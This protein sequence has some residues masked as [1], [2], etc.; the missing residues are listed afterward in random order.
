MKKLYG[1]GV[2]AGIVLG[3]ARKYAPQDTVIMRTECTDSENEIRVF[4]NALAQACAR[5][6]ALYAKIKVHS[7]EKEAEIFDA[8]L[9]V[10]TDDISVKNPI[11]ELIRSGYSAEQAVS[12]HFSALEDAMT[13]LEDD[14]LQARGS[15]FAA[16]K[17]M[18]LEELLGTG[19]FDLSSL[20]QDVIIVA[21][22]LTP[23]DTV[24][25]DLAHVKG[26]LCET[27]APTSHTAILA[28][29]LG[30]PAVVGCAGA[31]DSVQAG[32]SMLLDGEA[33][34]AIFSPDAHQ[35][36]LGKEKAAKLEQD[37][38]ALKQY[39]TAASRTI[40]GHTVSIHANI[41]SVSEC[42][43]AMKL[44]GEG[45]GLFRTEFLYME[46]PDLPDEERQ[47][48]IY[49][50]TLSAACGKPVTIRTLDAGGDKFISSLN[51]P[52][53]ENP[54]LGYRAIR[55]CLDQPSIFK[56]QL[57]ALYRA[58]TFGPLKIMFPMIGSLEELRAAKAI[59][60]AAQDELDCEGHPYSKD[61]KLGIMV[62]L[63]AV[64]EMAKEF[65]EEVDFFSIGTNDLVQYTLAVDRGNE[66]IKSLYT[67]YHPAVIRM[68][69]KSIDAA[70][71]SGIS[72]SMCGEA[73]GDLMFAPILLGFGLD[74][75]SV[76]A[77]SI[78]KLRQLICQS[79]LAC[80]QEFSQ[81]ILALRTAAEVQAALQQFR[82]VD[83]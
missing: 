48:E 4:E 33:G 77:S 21:R 37:A 60:K 80:C 41:G 34:V 32:E 14:Y 15:D 73:A 38:Q 30:I 26:I 29:A 71:K 70:H 23:S 12:L 5:T 72:C 81:K 65:A 40:D 35:T 31:F 6:E 1:V 44:G 74:A 52:R 49:R 10:L 22:E 61:V 54:F 9:A 24:Q 17:R 25:M 28:R 64:A 59:A 67:H 45:V 7:S 76:S 13:A 78:L 43:A 42:I 19:Q 16:L 82:E 11:I 83:S 20:D 69:K 63:P 58:S 18:L 66:K 39:L 53:E 36:S 50:D 79:S 2:S 55:I 62:E 68:I 27:G 47:Y 56:T 46:K 75:F 57:K 51:L 8:H 3:Q